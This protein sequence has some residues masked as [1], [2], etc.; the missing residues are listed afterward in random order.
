MRNF[1]LL[2]IIGVSGPFCVAESLISDFSINFNWESGALNDAI[3]VYSDNEDIRGNPDI[4]EFAY[5]F[6]ANPILRL[7]VN[8]ACTTNFML[9]IRARSTGGNGFDLCYNNYSYTPGTSIEFDIPITGYISKFLLTWEWTITAIP[10]CN[11]GSGFT[12]NTL[13]RT[14]EQHLYVILEEPQAPMSLPWAGVLEYA[15]EWA[16]GEYDIEEATSRITEHLYLCG[17]NYNIAPKYTGY[18]SNYF[19]ITKFLLDLEDPESKE[20]NCLDMARAVV[21]FSNAIGF[22]LKVFDYVSNLSDDHGFPVNFIDPIGISNPT[23]NPFPPSSS[24]I[25]NDCRTGGFTYHAFAMTPSESQIIPF[26][27]WDAT[28]RIDVDNDPDNVGHDPENPKACGFTTPGESWQLQS[29]VLLEDYLG[30]L[31]D[32]WVMPLNYYTDV[33]CNDSFPCGLL[34]FH[35]SDNPH[36]FLVE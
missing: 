27:A 14:T 7:Q 35:F 4:Y 28:L 8:T 9:L 34:Q 22:S 16:E 5:L 25:I 26:K 10:I 6:N 24:Q 32:D 11:T 3:P 23:N 33:D 30:R 21:T 2:I 31:V 20:V 13:T 15:C 17:F 29:G 19:K 12:A 36:D 18:T 1:L